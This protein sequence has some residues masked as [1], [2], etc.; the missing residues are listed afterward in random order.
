MDTGWESDQQLSTGENT[1]T[2][3]SILTNKSW[4][5]GID[6]MHLHQRMGTSHIFLSPN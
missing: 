6:G 5:T 3:V 4:L 1:H 2:S